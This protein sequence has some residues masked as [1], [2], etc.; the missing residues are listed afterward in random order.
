MNGS[1]KTQTSESQ[2]K[3]N[4]T[5]TSAGTQMCP[6]CYQQISLASDGEG[7]TIYADHVAQEKAW[8]DYMAS[9]NTQTTPSTEAPSSQQVILHSAHIVDNGF[10]SP[11]EA[12]IHISAQRLLALLIT[13]PARFVAIPIRKV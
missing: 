7:S 5:D 4:Q 13:L 10:P 6:Y 2:T 9:S 8:A 12:I 3:T 1:S 11:M